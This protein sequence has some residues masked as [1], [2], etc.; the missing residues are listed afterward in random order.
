MAFT[1]SGT[2]RDKSTG[3]PL[4]NCDV[5]LLKFSSDTFT[6][7]DFGTSDGSGEYSLTAGDGDSAYCVLAFDDSGSPAVAGTTARALTPE[8][9]VEFTDDD[10]A[11]HMMAA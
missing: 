8:S 9:T 4:G 7:I 6:Q 5:Y 11:A 10:Y 2:T 1:V 3:D